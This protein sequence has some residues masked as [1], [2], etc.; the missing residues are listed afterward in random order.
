MHGP[1]NIKLFPV[2]LRTSFMKD[3][4]VFRQI[5]QFE[6][7]DTLNVVRYI[8][9]ISNI[10]FPA[11]T[12]YEDGRDRVYRN[13]DIY[14]SDAGESPKRK[15]TTFRTPRKINITKDFPLLTPNFC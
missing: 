4:P 6:M 3:N 7:Q 11:Y 13:V 2:T 15:N 5:L 8:A 14:N 9:R 1:M 10:D 12:I